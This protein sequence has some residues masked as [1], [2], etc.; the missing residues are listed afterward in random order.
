MA[1]ESNGKTNPVLARDQVKYLALEGGGGKGFA[2]IGALQALEALQLLQYAD[3]GQLQGES[4]VKWMREMPKRI[5]R[6]Q[7]LSSTG[8][9]KGISGASAGAIT[10]LLLSCGYSPADILAIMASFK[11]DKFFEKPNPRVVPRIQTDRKSADYSGVM[12]VPNEP[13]KQTSS[14]LLLLNFLLA[15]LTGRPITAVKSLGTEV[16]RR[17][18]D[19]FLKAAHSTLEL[20]D[21]VGAEVPTAV[22][23]LLADFDYFIE[24]LDHDLGFFPGYEARKFFA[25]IIAHKMPNG[26]NATFAEHRAFFGVDLAVTGTN[27]ETGKSGVFSPKTSPNFPVAD[28]VRISMSLPLVYKPVR[29]LHDH[30]QWH[31]FG[32]RWVEG[33]WIDGGY[34]NN[35]PLQ[36]FDL[37]TGDNPK[38]LG[39]R[40]DLDPPQRH[41]DSLGKFLSVWPLQIGFGGPGEAYIAEALRN[42]G[43][44]IELSTEGLSL[45]NFAPDTKVVTG[46]LERGFEKVLRYFGVDLV[47]F[48]P[49][50]AELNE[51]LRGLEAVP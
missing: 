42:K 6:T 13:G 39:L 44:T 20:A 10:A 15:S 40:L 50:E 49:Y 1:Q 14:N 26:H 25:E 48:E 3:T 23:V 43:Q 16:R 46:V 21:A 9:I 38:T 28:A 32:E 31:R 11:F 30:Y 35:L 22:R 34:L 4:P 27:L 47:S 29:I 17:A 51:L 8:P 41:I 18:W 7:V 19:N 33:L 24:Y 36:V 5:S 37:E 2:F 45:L 12:A